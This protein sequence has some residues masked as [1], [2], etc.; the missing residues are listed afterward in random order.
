MRECLVAER[1]AMHQSAMLVDAHQFRA[2]GPQQQTFTSH[3]SPNTSL[4]RFKSTTS[5]LPNNDAK[6]SRLP[7][8]RISIVH[9]TNWNITERGKMK[10]LD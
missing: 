1:F 3:N 2:C 4:Y 6:V 7:M 8:A 10:K 5:K 9:R